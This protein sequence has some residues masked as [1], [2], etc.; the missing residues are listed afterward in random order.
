M[1]QGSDKM[2]GHVTKHHVM[3]LK[4]NYAPVLALPPLKDT[5]LRA[6]TTSLGM[7]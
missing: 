5:S 6:K 4:Q 7:L 3:F 2:A 1:K